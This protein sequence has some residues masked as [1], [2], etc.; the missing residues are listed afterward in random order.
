MTLSQLFFN[1]IRTIGWVSLLNVLR[2]H[3]HCRAAFAEASYFLYGELAISTYFAYYGV[4]T[5]SS[6]DLV[7]KALIVVY[8]LSFCGCLGQHVSPRQMQDHT[9]PGSQRQRKKNSSQL[10]ALSLPDL[11][12][13]FS[14]ARRC[15]LHQQQSAFDL[16]K[17]RWGSL[18][19]WL[20][21]SIC[22]TSNEFGCQC[23][24][25]SC[26]QTKACHK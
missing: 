17:K 8:Y 25:Q 19:W 16:H 21:R 18:A 20:S 1:S 9:W 26:I 23:T 10:L 6:Q 14:Q 13:L 15:V 11:R 5:T 4:K 22:S 12:V 7:M 24:T 3:P 2:G